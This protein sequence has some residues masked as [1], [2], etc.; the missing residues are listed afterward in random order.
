MH[1]VHIGA[2]NERQLR[3]ALKMQLKILLSIKERRKYSPIHF[4]QKTDVI[5]VSFL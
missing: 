4:K 2:A 3:A 5:F 1:R